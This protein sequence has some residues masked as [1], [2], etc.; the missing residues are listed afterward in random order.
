MSFTINIPVNETVVA[1][2]ERL[3]NQE[4][5][6]H[7]QLLKCMKIAFLAQKRVN[8]D[9]SST[10]DIDRLN[11]HITRR[12][13]LLATPL[14]NMTPAELAD[15]ST[16][17]QSITQ[18]GISGTYDHDRFRP[19]LT[20]RAKSGQGG[21]R[22]IIFS[23]AASSGDFTFVTPDKTISVVVRELILSD[24]NYNVEIYGYIVGVDNSVEMA[25][26]GNGGEIIKS[27]VGTNV[28]EVSAIT[29]QWYDADQ[30][31]APSY[32]NNN[33]NT[34]I[35][36]YVYFVPQKSIQ[37]SQL[38]SLIESH[39]GLDV[40]VVAN[41]IEQVAGDTM[42]SQLWGTWY[43]SYAHTGA[44]SVFNKS[45]VLFHLKSDTMVTTDASSNVSSWTDLVGGSTSFSQ[46]VQLNQPSQVTDNRGQ[47]AVL[48]RPDIKRQFLYN[49]VGIESL[50]DKTIIFVT[51]GWEGYTVPYLG[52]MY[53][54]YVSL[55]YGSGP[56]HIGDP[57]VLR[58]GIG[59]ND[60]YKIYART[61][62]DI[63][64][65]VTALYGQQPKQSHNYP[66]VYNNLFSSS[67]NTST[68]LFRTT[69]TIDLGAPTPIQRFWE[70]NTTG[71]GL[72]NLF[73]IGS[74][75]PVYAGYRPFYMYEVL[76]INKPTLTPTEIT[77][78][79][80]YIASTYGQ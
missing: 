38:Y 58:V 72:R 79:N 67:I 5:G 15:F 60:Q 43:Y 32:V 56:N 20:E 65:S 21:E 13:Q 75:V 28:P 16:M 76:V 42:G 34:P 11:A 63:S 52:G 37:L 51:R 61:L 55:S 23:G 70:S 10:L 9:G 78:L 50:T 27:P 2:N 71:T 22:R 49:D 80:A 8:D 64:S 69:S 74:D 4:L 41:T 3:K 30:N 25:R 14:V 73:V 35:T 7:L 29:E 57:T 77:N 6:E 18:T 44:G 36:E 26:L 59:V 19:V 39:G 53:R 46:P 1:R 33:M 12:D 17:K 68:G 31:V 45:D 54:S 66:A 24:T 48:F 47:T 62:S 40:A